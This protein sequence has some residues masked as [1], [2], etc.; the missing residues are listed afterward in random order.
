MV[1]FITGKML[2]FSHQFTIPWKKTAKLIEQGKHGKLV[3]GSILQK[4]SYVDNLGNFYSYFSY[5]RSA[6]FPLDS[7]PMVYLIAWKM[8]GFS[9]KI[10]NSIRKGSKTHRMGNAQEVGF[11]TFSIKCVVF[12]IR[13]P[14]CGILHHMGNAWV[15][16]PIS[17]SIGKG[18]K[19]HQ[20]G[21]ALKIVSKENPTKSIVCGE[22]GKLVLTLFPQ[23]GRFFPIRLTS[24]GKLYTM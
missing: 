16:S 14:S 5:S 20:F 19:I 17:L 24:C 1:Y 8:H 15:F 7:H 2:V 11:H 18:R 9:Y 13:F 12:S 21:K 4:P 23:Y 10:S 6:F 22:P 3:A